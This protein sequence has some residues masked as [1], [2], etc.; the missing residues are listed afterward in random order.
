[1]ALLQRGLAIATAAGRVIDRLLLS[2][3]LV[4]LEAELRGPYSKW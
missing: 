3:R 2:P 4:P 1:M